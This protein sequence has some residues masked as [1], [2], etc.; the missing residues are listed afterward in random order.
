MD[1]F[2]D[3]TALETMSEDKIQE[4][5]VQAVEDPDEWKLYKSLFDNDVAES[6]KVIMMRSIAY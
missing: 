5:L 4:R 6:K 3:P 1:F 2:P